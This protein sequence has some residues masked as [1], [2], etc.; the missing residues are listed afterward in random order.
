MNNNKK[1][2]LD[3]ESILQ[4]VK[5]VLKTEHDKDVAVEIGMKPNA[6]YNRKASGSVPMT[7]FVCLANRKNVNIEW[8]VNGTGP[9]YKD[10]SKGLEEKTPPLKG[11]EKDPPEIS[12]ITRVIIEHQKLLTLFKDQERAKEINE[13]LIEIEQLSEDLMESIA[14]HIKTSLTAARIIQGSSKKKSGAGGQDDLQNG[15]TA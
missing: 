13:N 6:F 11:P 1:N 5:L 2:V 7:E 9:I 14:Q 15:K 3:F 4:R 10:G 12:N 8:L